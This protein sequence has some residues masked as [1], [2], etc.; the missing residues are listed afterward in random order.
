MQL[1]KTHP[2]GWA[3]S[4]IFTPPQK[5]DLIIL[6]KFCIFIIDINFANIDLNMILKMKYNMKITRNYSQRDVTPPTA[7]ARGPPHP[8]STLTIVR[9]DNI[10]NINNELNI[11]NHV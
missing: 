3:F 6:K 10:Y 2:F 11:H 1:L 8:F 4:S 7:S 5:K 9:Q